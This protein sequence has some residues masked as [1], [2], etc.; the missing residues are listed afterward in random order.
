MKSLEGKSALVTG[1][2]RGLGKDIAMSLAQAGASVM[3]TARTA[4][5]TD[6]HIPGSLRNTVEQS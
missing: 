2:S 6:S 4:E 1:A 5:E 3:V